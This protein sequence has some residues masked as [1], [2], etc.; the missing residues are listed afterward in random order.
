MPGIPGLLFKIKFMTAQKQNT[1]KEN[2]NTIYY[3]LRNSLAV[4]VTF[5][6]LNAPAK[7]PVTVLS[8]NDTIV[9]G[10]VKDVNGIPIANAKISSP[11]A[12]DVYTN[13]DGLFS[14]T[15]HTEKIV[16][17]SFIF[18]YDTLMQVVRSY[19]PVM[20][21]TAYEIIL[22]PKKCCLRDLWIGICKHTKNLLLPSVNFT[23]RAT[24][25][26]AET[27]IALKEIAG[28]LRE[29]P[30]AIITITAYPAQ[31]D[32]KQRISAKRLQNIFEHLVEKE[33]ISSDRIKTEMKSGEGDGNIIDFKNQ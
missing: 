25:L 3:W 21:N 32:P 23:P 29:N 9:S 20:A 1:S 18:T 6:T 13:S 22:E 16:P 27:K 10:I 2:Y 17:Q 26:S 7:S 14:I 30:E 33:G 31:N 11:I 24:A 5:T 28:K 8:I 15:L 4:I 19:H 12:G